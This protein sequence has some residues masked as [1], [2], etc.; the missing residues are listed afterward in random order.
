MEQKPT[1]CLALADEHVAGHHTVL[2][3]V[4]VECRR[5]PRPLP[6]RAPVGLSP[7]PASAA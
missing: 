6:E 7:R 2:I 3:E 1:A 5:E 4:C